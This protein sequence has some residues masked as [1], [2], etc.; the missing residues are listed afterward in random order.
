MLSFTVFGSMLLAVTAGDSMIDW[1]LSPDLVS[2][3]LTMT[4]ALAHRMDRTRLEGLAAQ[5]TGGLVLVLP[6]NE[7]W[8]GNTELYERLMKPGAAGEKLR[9]D[10][11]FAAGGEMDQVGGFDA[12]LAFASRND[13]VVDTAFGTPM[14]I[15]SDGRV[16]LAEYD[17]EYFFFFFFFFFLTNLKSVN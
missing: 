1:L 10:L 5:A 17:A 8:L 6:T 11:L 9:N 14:K 16:C 15:E 7:A 2:P 12:L 13:G 3:D 4:Q